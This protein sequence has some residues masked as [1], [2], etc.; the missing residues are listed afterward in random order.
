MPSATQSRPPNLTSEDF[1]SNVRQQ[2]TEFRGASPQI[3][4]GL[5]S[6]LY[7]NKNSFEYDC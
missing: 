7:Q 1:I 3:S 6:S 4:N 2:L 5:S